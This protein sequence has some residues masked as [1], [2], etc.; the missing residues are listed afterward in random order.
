MP[1]D[2]I[3]TFKKSPLVKTL[4]LNHSQNLVEF[5]RS[6]QDEINQCITQ[7][8]G[9][10]IRGCP[11]QDELEFQAI[12]ECLFG[13]CLNYI[14][15]VSPRSQRKNKI[16]NSTYL[17]N[18]MVIPQHR[19][20]S[21]L[22]DYP[23]RINFYCQSPAKTGGQTP[24]TDFVQVYIALQKS[25]PELMHNMLES[26]VL[27]NKVY[28]DSRFIK[29]QFGIDYYW[30]WRETFHCDS[31][32]ELDE[33]GEKLGVIFKHYPG[34]SAMI[35]TVPIATIHP[36]HKNLVFFANLYLN[37]RT[38]DLYFKL[39]E[40]KRLFRQKLH[41]LLQSQDDDVYTGDGLL[42]PEK[43]IHEFDKAVRKNTYSF[44]WQANDLLLLDNNW[45]G[46]GRTQFVG[47]NRTLWA[48]MNNM[49]KMDPE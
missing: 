42:I 9:L 49:N 34:Y 22:P 44:D 32:D 16:Y 17:A 37:K 26:G 31:W 7:H 39:T 15:G 2:L 18:D 48:C 47:D 33:I 1:L 46:H 8:G 19:E 45:L 38:L 29:K 12:T 3:N 35:V 11:L 25:Q 30:G 5:V 6:H 28:Y 4:V 27:I 20:M 14:G 43:F 40:P 41:T 21:Y 24:I 10:L 23:D 36:I 13:P